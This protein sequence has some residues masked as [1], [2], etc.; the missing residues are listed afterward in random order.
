MNRGEVSAQLEC[1]FHGDVG[2]G[3]RAGEV[4]A[5]DIDH[6][7]VKADEHQLGFFTEGKTLLFH[8]RQLRTRTAQFARPGPQQVHL[9]ARPLSQRDERTRHLDLHRAVEGRLVKP[10]CRP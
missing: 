9:Y 10:P 1:P 5:P 8:L 3:R 7:Q 6:H 4:A 2:D